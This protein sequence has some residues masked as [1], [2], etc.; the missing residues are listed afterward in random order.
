MFKYAVKIETTFASKTA[1]E[2]KVLKGAKKELTGT[3][4]HN[5]VTDAGLDDMA[6]TCGKATVTIE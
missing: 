3:F 4:P 5:A 2:P 6:V 1:I